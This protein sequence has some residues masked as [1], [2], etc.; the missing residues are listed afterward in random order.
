MSAP[1]R[2][3]RYGAAGFDLFGTILAGTAIGYFLDK[4]LS[5][6]PY[7]TLVLMLL[8]IVGG[9]IRLIRTLR[10]FDQLDDGRD[11]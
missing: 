10:H 9:F 7:L 5:T 4:W 2:Y 6:A 8:S 1:V 3:A 11:A